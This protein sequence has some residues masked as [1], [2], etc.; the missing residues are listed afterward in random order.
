MPLCS[1]L[2]E[3]D[4][5]RPLG[6]EPAKV[7]DVVLCSSLADGRRAVILLEVKLRE[8]DFTHCDGRKSPANHHR[9]VCETDAR[10]LENPKAYWLR[11]P[12]RKQ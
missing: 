5:D 7:V 8:P 12:L 6:S 11:R 4:G 1:Q 9:H 10:L 2:V 3:I